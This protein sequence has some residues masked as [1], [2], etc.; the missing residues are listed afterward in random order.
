MRIGFDATALTRRTTTGVA[1]YAEEIIKRSIPLAPDDR[2]VLS[3]F[4]ADPDPVRPIGDAHPNVSLRPIRHLPPRWYRALFVRRV[5]PP[6]DLLARGRADVY[7][8]PD[9]IRWP[10][11]SRRSI[12]VVH[13]LGFVK[14]PQFVQPGTRRFLQ[15]FAPRS[16]AG[17]DGIVAVSEF[18]KR[19]LI[20]T[21]GLDPG[22]V[23]V[24]P[25]GVDHGH[26]YPRDRTEVDAVKTRFGIDRPY[27]LMT[28]TIEPR[29]NVDGL[30]KA[31]AS[32]AAPL[33]DAHSLVLAGG[34]GWLDQNIL[35]LADELRASGVRVIQ[36]GYVEPRD[37]PALYSGASVFVLPSHYEGFGIPVV[38]AMAC[39][40]PVITS[41][42]ASLPEVA[43]EAAMLVGTEDPAELPGAIDRVL[44]DP[45]VREDLRRRGLERARAF[46][47]DA[48]AR[49]MLDFIRQVRDDPRVRGNAHHRNAV[50]S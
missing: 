23:A 19:E 24:V 26:F 49:A 4:A 6:F 21:Y 25:N 32:I 16:V 29:K 45:A 44:G 43:G 9:F 46:S 47:W 13:D 42:N 18:T 14:H 11:L 40:A 39:G 48:S 5:A 33:R 27:V 50:G 34:E 10:V 12:V 28:G 38:E 17:A 30:L 35:R 22:R 31:F 7:V 8:F 37:L 15:T 41:R 3:Y 1:R 20:G 2:F 36:L